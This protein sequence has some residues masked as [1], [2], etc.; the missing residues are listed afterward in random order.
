MAQNHQTLPVGLISH[1]LEDFPAL[2]DLSFQEQ[3]YLAWMAWQ[4]HHEYRQH[5]RHSSAQWFH[6]TEIYRWFGKGKFEKLNNT[7]GMFR[8]SSNWS[9]SQGETK[10]FWMTPT[11]EHSVL[12]FTSQKTLTVI[13]VHRADGKVLKAVPAPLRSTS[14]APWHQQVADS[15]IKHTTLNRVQVNMNQM[16]ELSEN[17]GKLLNIDAT[18]SSDD[19]AAS[20]WKFARTKEEVASVKILTDKLRMLAQAPYGEVGS[21]VHVYTECPSGRVYANGLNLQNAPRIIKWHALAHHWEY[22]IQ[23]CHFSVIGQLAEQLG[24]NCE[25]IYQYINNKVQFREAL[26]EKVGISVQQAKRCLI[27]LMYGAKTLLID[28]CAIPKEIGATKAELLYATSEFAGLSSDL[29]IASQLITDQAT[30]SGMC[31][32]KNAYGKTLL[33]KSS[34][35]QILSHLVQGVERCALEAAISICKDDVV[36]LQHD[37]IVT[38]KRLEK[39]SLENE[40]LQKTGFKLMIDEKQLQ[41][42]LISFLQNQ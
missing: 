20:E 21:I 16:T 1:L 40:I 27:A 35:S 28:R 25:S 41:P 19:S 29:K 23:N 32:P 33:G 13:G 5:A 6:H 39:S 3:W 7:V 14:S 24:F 2:T 22:D 34:G 11:L 10:A 37:A 12:R 26:A 17:L 18:K 42:N 36:L 9:V 38:K 4:G 15:V 8:L 30:K 31:L